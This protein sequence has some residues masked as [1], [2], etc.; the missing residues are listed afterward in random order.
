ML[1]QEEKQ[2]YSRQIMLAG[3]GERGQ[4]RLKRARVLIAGLGG[5]GCAASTYLTVAGVGPA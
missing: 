1:T 5:L 3:F 4:R 2:R